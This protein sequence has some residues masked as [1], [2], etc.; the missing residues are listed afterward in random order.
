MPEFVNVLDGNTFIV[1]DVSGDISPSP[2]L[3]TGM[4]SF[5]TRF[6]STWCLTVHGER[7]HALGYDDLQYY[8]SL[9]FLVPGAPTLYV[10]AKISVI[11]ERTV[12]GSFSE[13][14]TVLNHG[15]TLADLTIRM[16]MG[17]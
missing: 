14:V 9:F 4:F 3:P 16:E 15:D 17:C 6:L 12:G 13:S 10:D 1:S 5:D 8:E 7:L 11:R 2:T